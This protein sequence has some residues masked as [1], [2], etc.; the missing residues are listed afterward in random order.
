MQVSPISNK[1]SSNNNSGI[2]FRALIVEPETLSKIFKNLKTE[3]LIEFKNIVLEQNKNPIHII[4][5]SPKNRLEASLYCQYRLKNFKEKY[6]QIPII[7]SQFNFIKRIVN[8]ANKYK[9][10]L[11][12]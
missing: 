11:I 5:N 1:I 12:R 7:E 9:K 4:L 6:K 2:A 10:Q 3:Q 8:K